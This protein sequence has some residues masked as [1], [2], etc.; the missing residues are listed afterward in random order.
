[1]E[2]IDLILEDTRERMEKS[3][4]FLISELKKIR[5]GKAMPNMLDGVMIEYYGV[6]TPLIQVASIT[7]PDSRTLFI[8]PWEKSIIQDVEKAIISSDLGLNPQ[9]DGENIIINIP[10]L[11]EERRLVL[12]K[13]IKGEGEKGKISIRSV[14]KE[15]NEY[16]K[17]LSNEGLSEDA[18]RDGED[19]IQ[20]IT[21][22]KIN[23]IDEIIKTKETEITTI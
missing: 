19:E 11:T 2:E 3:I 18:I 17:K 21:D 22:I 12:V 4:H 5:A 7:T 14:R 6:P 23:R 1:M 10:P 16:L 9:N 8:R 13:Q 20:K 15:S